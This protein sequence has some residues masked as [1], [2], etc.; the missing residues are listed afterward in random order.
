MM[1]RL[2]DGGGMGKAL[3]RD[4]RVYS[5]SG[6]ATPQPHRSTVHLET[7][8]ASGKSGKSGGGGECRG[9]W[10]RGRY[11]GFGAIARMGRST[12]EQWQAGDRHS[13]GELVAANGVAYTGGWRKGLKSGYRY[14]VITM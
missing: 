5:G 4:G 7:Q 6:T 9:E 8:P 11:E 3:N 10:V 14:Y 2:A 1:S 13:E 12:R